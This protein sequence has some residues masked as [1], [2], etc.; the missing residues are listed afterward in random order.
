MKKT[1]ILAGM[2]TLSGCAVIVTPKPI[3]DYSTSSLCYSV[4]HSDYSE[5]EQAKSELLRRNFKPYSNN[6]LLLSE[7]IADQ[8]TAEATAKET[9]ITTHKP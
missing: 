3:T 2:M 4:Y 8:K 7:K 5:S 6:C 1:I 9:N